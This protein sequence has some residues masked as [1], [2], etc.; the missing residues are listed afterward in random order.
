MIEAATH[1]RRHRPVRRRLPARVRD[2]VVALSS[3]GVLALLVGYAIA[4]PSTKLSAS[5]SVVARPG[6]KAFVYGRVLK[7]DGDGL[8]G[9]TIDIRRSGR[10][11]AAAASDDAG[12][13]R[14]ELPRVCAAYGISLR[15]VTQGSTMTRAWRRHL[16]PG[17]S[18]A[19]DARVAT[20][21]H[22]LWVPGPR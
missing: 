4:G 12:R 9:A 6:A 7:P 18:L 1:S 8:D 17:Q 13:F 2:A 22:F 14:V 19:I 3:A 15:A 20:M 5:A 21:G 10:P 11:V 16:C